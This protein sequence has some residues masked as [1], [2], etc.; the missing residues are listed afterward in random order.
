MIGFA[1]KKFF[2]D[3]WDNL[4]FILIMNISFFLILAL[5]IYIPGLI[6]PAFSAVGMLFLVVL[7]YIL[8]VF[9]CTATATLKKISDYRHA[10][11]KDFTANI[12]GALIPAAVL[13]GVSVFAFLLIRITIP[14]YISM[15]NPVGLGLAF[16]FFWICLII[17]VSVLFYPAIYY[18]LG[19]NP[20]KCLKKCFIF[21]FDNAG[22]CIVSLI[23]SILLSVF[24]FSF[25]GFMFSYLDQAL[26]LRLLK[27]DW[28]EQNREQSVSDRKRIKIPWEKLLEEEKEKTG[29]RSFKSFFFP[30]KD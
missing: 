14:F 8:F 15:L 21:F 18:R 20:L 9:I 12:K 4:I 2:Y 27:Y 5:A 17:I 28:L 19:E 30:W 13:Y 29:E 1:F 22:F 24:V 25:P 7:G 26:R 23:I 16:L 11:F 10:G 6:P 3:M